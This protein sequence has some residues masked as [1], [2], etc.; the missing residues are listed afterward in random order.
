MTS[1]AGTLIPPRSL[2]A[3]CQA[4]A[5]NP[6]HGP[7]FMAAMAQAGEQGIGRKA[8][9]LYDGSRIGAACPG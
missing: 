4:R 3:S 9:G 8:M 1:S 6:L 7:A 5:D 2:A